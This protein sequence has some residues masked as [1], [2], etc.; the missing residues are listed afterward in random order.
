[1]S[2][3]RPFYA[4]PPHRAGRGGL[5][6][7][8]AMAADH[9]RSM[10]ALQPNG[11]YLL[12]GHCNGGLVALEMARKL[13]Q[14]GERV[15]LLVAIA[16]PT[17]P[18]DSSKLRRLARLSGRAGVG[19]AGQRLLFSVLRRLSGD[20][21]NAKRGIQQ[22]VQ[23]ALM[24]N[25]PGRPQRALQP[26]DARAAEIERDMMRKLRKYKQIIDDYTYFVPPYEGKAAL[27][28]PELE[29]DGSCEDA[30]RG[31]K[32]VIPSLRIDV[33]PGGHLTCIT[34]HAGQVG[35]L[36]KTLLGEAAERGTTRG[37][38]IS[39]ALREMPGVIA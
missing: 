15:D 13:R 24:L 19:L 5:N 25:G 8:E 14:L 35:E 34:Q 11:P 4:L 38:A 17:L 1:M 30:S 12:G 16:L 29:L 32:R 6:S 26:D 23:A 37:E 3:E 33:V 18:P 2:R 28:V 31:W 36:L 21:R 7:I 9:L 39:Y 10:R 22:R 20:L 27:I